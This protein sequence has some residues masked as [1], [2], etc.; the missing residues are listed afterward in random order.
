MP[1]SSVPPDEDDLSPLSGAQIEIMNLVWARGETTVTEIWKALQRARPVA[2]T[3]V[4]TVMDRLEKKGWLKRRL[5][6]QQH[7]YSAARSREATLG[8]MVERLVATAFA[9]SAEDLVVAL[10]DGRGVTKDEAKRIR[11]L[12]E[13]ARRKRS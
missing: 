2:R 9:G 13:K 11:T 10:L 3:T 4:L 6:E 5:A 7:L 12:I 1:P 8:G